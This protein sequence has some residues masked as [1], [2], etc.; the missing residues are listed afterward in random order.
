VTVPHSDAQAELSRKRG[1]GGAILSHSDPG[2]VAIETMRSLRTSLQF[3]LVE[4]QNNVVAMAGP[5]P[6]VGKSF[7]AQN[8]AHVLA[9]AGRKVLLIDCD[10]RRG[11]LHRHFGLERKPGL[12]DLVSGEA[13]LE[14]A[15][16]Q[17]DGSSLF[18][19]PTGRIPPNPAELL[20][21]Q[22]FEALLR[23]LSS[24][25]ELVVVDTP[26]ILAVSDAMLVSRLAGVNLMVFRAGMHTAREIALSVKQFA[27]NGVRLHG[28]ILNDV[29][30][31]RGGRYGTDGYMRYEYTSDVS[32]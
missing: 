16:H 11:H 18:L 2:D 5:A 3:A 26:P 13:T 19:L 21:S 29:R 9:M 22:R 28:S 7:L 6:G 15:V 30:A 1:R 31:T 32:D 24:R 20:S 10:L 8:L 27:L 12:S 17:I 23:D 14:Q 25:F 4:A